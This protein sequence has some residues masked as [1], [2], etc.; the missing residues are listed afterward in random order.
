MQIPKPSAP[1]ICLLRRHWHFLPSVSYV[2]PCH[3][4]RQRNEPG[5]D[6]MVKLSGG[7]SLGL[8]RNLM[9]DPTH[10]LQRATLASQSKP[11][12]RQREGYNLLNCQPQLAFFCVDLT[13]EEHSGLWLY[14]LSL[15]T[16]CLPAV[17]QPPI[18]AGQGHT[19]L[20]SSHTEEEQAE[21]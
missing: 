13:K 1:L 3:R 19:A 5:R 14:G 12:A 10:D 6:E 2:F 11:P 8:L 15:M 18:Y 17:C 16:V 20:T 21:R 7:L 9:C 4:L